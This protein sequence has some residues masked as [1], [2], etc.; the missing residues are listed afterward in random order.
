MDP[1]VIVLVVVI[2]VLVIALAAVGI[3]LSRRR[4]S[5]RLQEHYGPEYERSVLE[6]GDRRTAEA[7]LVERE[8]RHSELD[9]RDLDPDERA[10]FSTS[11]TTIQRDFVDDPVSAVRS[12][13]DLVV[14]IMRT[15]GYPVDDAE[16]RTE[17]VSVEHPGVVQ[18]Y[19]EARR[20]R[21]A[22]DHGEVD[23][24]QQRHAVTS[25]RSL[26]EALLGTGSKP[27]DEDN[28]DHDHRA[29]DTDDTDPDDTDPT[30]SDRTDTRAG[31]NGH[32]N[33]DVPTT[34][35]HNR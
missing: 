33:S 8:R 16:R 1:T 7:Q 26:V 34:E 22:T 21:E 3:L 11:W 29:A 2:V 19:R 35:E 23:L 24:D 28:S 31:T 27:S 30:G 14:D 12:A 25:Y 18:Q 13:D 20:I 10:R 6:T 5:E 17:D 15:R 9:V 4:H 32:R